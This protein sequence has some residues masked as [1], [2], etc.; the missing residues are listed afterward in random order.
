MPWRQ[1]IIAILNSASH[2]QAFDFGCLSRSTIR[3]ALF[4]LS[5]RKRDCSA[6]SS[7]CQLRIQCKNCFEDLRTRTAINSPLG[8]D[9]CYREV[10][11]WRPQ[12]HM[13][14]YAHINVRILGRDRLLLHYGSFQPDSQFVS[15]GAG[16]TCASGGAWLWK[17]AVAA[18]K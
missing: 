14:H 1:C 18:F 2:M 7:S 13:H 11:F 4:D 12:V 16:R 5:L 9:E 8:T 15:V 17:A 3:A 10:R 6:Q